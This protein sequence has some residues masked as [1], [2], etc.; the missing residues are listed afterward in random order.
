MASKQH[1]AS[2]SHKS[3][4]VKNQILMIL[5]SE[6]G[7]VTLDIIWKTYKFKCY[8]RII[9]DD[10]TTDYVICELCNHNTLIKNDVFNRASSISN[11]LSS[12][13]HV[14]KQPKGGIQTSINF[15]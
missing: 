8:K 1:S 13:Y 10:D 11:H 6:K 3:I 9:I 15:Y 2:K 14:Q 12:L 4:L 7:R 5:R